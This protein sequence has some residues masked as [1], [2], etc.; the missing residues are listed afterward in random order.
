MPSSQRWASSDR[1]VDS[2]R[3]R[4]TALE[5]IAAAA[6]ALYAGFTPSQQS[7]ADPTLATIVTLVTGGGPGSLPERTGKPRTSP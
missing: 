6:K 2:A 5:D 4:L 3:N 1:A 7:V